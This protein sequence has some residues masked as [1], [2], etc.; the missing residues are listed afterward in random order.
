LAKAKRESLYDALVFSVEKFSFVKAIDVAVAVC[1]HKFV[2]I[3]ASVNFSSKFTD[4]SVVEGL[5]EKCAEVYTNLYGIAGIEGILPNRYVEEFLLYNTASRRAVADFFDIFN[6]RMLGLRYM[7]MKQHDVRSLSCPVEESI[8]GRIIFSLAGFGFEKG[9]REL[10]ASVIP[11]QLKISSQ[12]LFWQRTRTSDGIRALLSG[13][14]ELPVRIRQFV[15]GFV[16]IEKSQQSAIGSRK[17][18]YNSLGKDCF[19]GNKVWEQA[20]GVDIEIGPLDFMTYMKFLPRQS[21]RDQQF[22]PLQKV[23][24]IVKMYVPYGMDV[25]LR[26][27]LE[28][29]VNSELPLVGTKRLNKDS[30]LCNYAYNEMGTC[31]T[32]AV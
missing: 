15:G 18:R 11:H 14:L 6:G 16:E 32:E 17:K 4:V 22:S 31:F 29:N 5:S 23:K 19:L 1:G 2:S 24:E 8:I 20:K 10:E 28:A 25:R 27:Y 9:E 3:R 7:F 12:N 26:F 30:F 13:F 21:E